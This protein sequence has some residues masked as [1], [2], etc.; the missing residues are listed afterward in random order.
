MGD[1][2]FETANVEQNGIYTFTS[3]VD[4]TRFTVEWTSKYGMIC[5]LDLHVY[6]YDERVRSQ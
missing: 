3:D 4:T 5:D 1:E 6:C 2:N